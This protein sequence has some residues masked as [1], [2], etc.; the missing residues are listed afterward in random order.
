MRNRNLQIGVAAL[1]ATTAVV[2]SGCSTGPTGGGTSPE[3]GGG[4]STQ[5]PADESA[6][7]V[8]IE[9]V[10]GETTID[11]LP[12]RV[13]TV[14]WSDQDVVVALG[15]VPVGATKITWG[16]NEA[17]S[18]DY[19]DEALAELDPN[20][21][22]TRYDDSDGI[23]IDEIAALQPDLILGVNSGL[24]EEEYDQLSKIADTIAYP[25]IAWGTSWEDSL[26]IIGTA[27]GRSDKAAEVRA[28][29]NAMLD[30]VTVDYPQL[31]GMSFAWTWFNAADLSTIGI[32]TPTDLRPQMM[33]R[34]GMVDAPKVIEISAGTDGF[35]ANLSAE[36]SDQLDADL[37]VFYIESAGQDEQFKAD[38]LIG[39]IP[40][41]Q[42]GAY[43][44]SLDNSIALTMSSPSPLSIPV[45]IEAF[46]PQIVEAAANAT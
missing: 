8:T 10:Y 15:E 26:E 38:P 17:G 45:A 13:A 1:A 44:A 18:T 12:T 7:P 23:P 2:F 40:A 25:K 31:E 42:R 3:A 29:T 9:H 22:I 30:Q 4:M 32:Y 41:L 34:F 16:G 6:F 33:R 27:L 28:A 37:I 11:Q 19:F 14:G 46:L 39:Q 43:V 5:A 20:A 35:S 21:E 36:Q 24:T